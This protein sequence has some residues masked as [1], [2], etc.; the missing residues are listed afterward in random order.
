MDEQAT[1]SGKT[2]TF[3][4]GSPGGSFYTK[5][6]ECQKECYADATGVACDQV[7]GE[8]PTHSCLETV[9]CPPVVTGCL[10]DDPSSYL[11]FTQPVCGDP[12][13][14]WTGMTKKACP[15]GTTCLGSACTSPGS[16]ARAAGAGARGTA[17]RA[18]R[19]TVGRAAPQAP[20]WPDRA[21]GAG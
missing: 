17:G 20:A 13:C 9:E 15:A 6:H 19:G 1:C 3:Y 21:A 11:E 2:I 14:K 4:Y 16:G 12:S 5:T 8:P 10:T 18:A 7:P